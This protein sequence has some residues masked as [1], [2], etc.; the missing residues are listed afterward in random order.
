VR[1]LLALVLL[2]L[3][4]STP[5]RTLFPDQARA[6]WRKQLLGSWSLDAWHNETQ[7][8]AVPFPTRVRC[9]YIETIEHGQAVIRG[10]RLRPL[11][12]LL[13]DTIGDG[14]RTGSLT[15]DDGNL[16]VITLSTGN[17]PWNVRIE[18]DPSQRRL[19]AW[20]QQGNWETNHLERQDVETLLALLRAAMPKDSLLYSRRFGC[21]PVSAGTHRLGWPPSMDA[22]PEVTTRVAPSLPAASVAVGD[23][24]VL[25]GL[26]DS[27]GRLVEIRIKRSV[28]ELDQ[29]AIEAVE[30]W[31]FNPARHNGYAT[32]AW[33]TL[34]IP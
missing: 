33:V 11:R 22:L 28:A 4:A 8:R 14:N 17:A 12:K 31:H 30:Q 2:T 26:I 10:E 16:D 29:S 7:L 34:R 27:L 19:D 15:C 6:L 32:D 1:I 21:P 9:R 25:H 3:P 20:D 13:A 18:F 5:A 24:V 23:T